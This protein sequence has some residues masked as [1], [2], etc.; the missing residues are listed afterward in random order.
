[1]IFRC[2]AP[3]RICDLGGW[4]DTWF[5]QSGCILNIAVYPCVEV[6]VKVRKRVENDSHF[7]IRAE[8][9]GETL[10]FPRTAKAGQDEEMFG[11]YALLR[12]ACE[13]FS[14]PEALCFEVSIFSEAPAGASIGTS[15]SVSVAILGALDLFAQSQASPYQIAQKAHHLESEVLGWQSGVQ[16]QFAAV[17][18]GISFIEVIRYPDAKIS[19]VE[20]SPSLF[21]ELESRLLLV[22]L[23]KPHCSSEVHNRVIAKMQ[24]NPGYRKHLQALAACADKGR[25]ALLKGDLE[26]FGRTMIDNT[27][28]QQSMDADLV[29]TQA[30][31]LISLA[32]DFGACGY[33]V[34]GAGGDGGSI[35]L[36]LPPNLDLKHKWMEAI[37]STHPEFTVISVKIAPVGFQRW[38]AFSDFRPS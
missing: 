19:P 38:R 23:G 2:K 1:M 12:V 13:A 21:N 25:E 27:E 11:K 8:N 20:I 34:N 29:G 28:I 32:K 24:S 36:L 5:A 3:V 30:R 4:T 33:K 7:I 14:L 35:T 15:A 37:R 10:H 26:A 31:K 18:G 6:S 22:Y 17:H 9:Y 16:D